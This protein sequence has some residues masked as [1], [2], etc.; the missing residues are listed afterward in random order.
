VTARTLSLDIVTPDGTAVEERG[1]DAVV[2]H[3]RER[4]FEVGSEIAVLPLHAPMLVRIPIG[5][6]R[7]RRGAEIVH[8][9]LRGGFAQV[10]A[11]RVLIA[12]PR[13]ERIP[14]A[15][16]TPLH[17]ARELCSGWEE[18]GSDFRDEMTGY[19]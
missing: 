17:T 16:P 6:A 11:D 12:T 10:L 18:E 9:A 5:P 13:V 3:R 7:F 4:L 8:L 2:F 1:V 19:S 15:D 14:T